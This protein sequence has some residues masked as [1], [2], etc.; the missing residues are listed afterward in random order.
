MFLSIDNGDNW[1][2]INSGL[3]NLDVASLALSHN[4]YIFAGTGSGVFRS[5][6]S[7]TS[8]RELSPAM[9]AAFALEQNYPNPFNPSTEIQFSLPQK[10]HVTL[11]IFDLLGRE[12]TTLVFEE[13]SAGSH[14]ERWHA[15]GFPSGVYFY[16]LTASEFTQTKKLLL[17][18]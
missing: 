6:E 5:V 15:V 18:K 4:G 11:T 1:A 7:T 16:T 17:V 3:T 9:P 10:T 2:Q 14:S 12:V 8:V 13:L